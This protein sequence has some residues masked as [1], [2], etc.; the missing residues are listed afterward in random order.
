MKWLG[1]AGAAVLMLA[2]GVAQAADGGTNCSGSLGLAKIEIFI[3]R[4]SAGQ[5]PLFVRL[6]KDGQVIAEFGAADL[7]EGLELSHETDEV[8]HLNQYLHGLNESGILFLRILGGLGPE[9]PEVAA[10]VRLDIPSAGLAGAV[11]E[12]GCRL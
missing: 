3:G 5:S 2:G 6:S 10:E 7:T 11:T 1:A 4:V 12:I 8:P 9:L